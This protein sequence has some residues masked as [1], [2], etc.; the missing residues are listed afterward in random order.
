[1]EIDLLYVAPGSASK[2][3]KPL[4]QL[5]RIQV[6]IPNHLDEIFK[7]TI[8]KSSAN[9]PDEAKK[10]LKEIIQKTAIHSRR[11]IGGI[12]KRP[13]VETSK[14]FDAVWVLERK[15]GKVRFALNRQN[16][17]LSE[18]IDNPDFLETM[19]SMIES[20]LPIDLIRQQ[21]QPSLDNIC[22]P[23]SDHDGLAMLARAVADSLKSSDPDITTSELRD[24]ISS[25][26]FFRNTPELINEVLKNQNLLTST[27]SK[28]VGY[29]TSLL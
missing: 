10:Y 20:S 28:C 17:L 23:P 7:L 8:D 6:D 18:G 24:K 9:L 21:L 15:A 19:L 27:P 4:D 16:P 11:R 14:K 29:T 5:L 1:M 3:F 2:L 26:D 22:Q 25:F 13:R 12:G